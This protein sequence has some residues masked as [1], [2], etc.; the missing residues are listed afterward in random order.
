[1]PKGRRG[2]LLIVEDDPVVGAVLTLLVSTVHEVDSFSNGQ[3]AL[4]RFVPGQYDAALIDLGMPEMP[5]DHLA[6][7]LRRLDPLV[8]TVMVTGWD[9]DTA[10]PRL[11]AF[12]FRVQKPIASVEMQ[13]VV[14]QAVVLHDER[15]DSQGNGRRS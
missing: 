13:R 5:G 12:D 15:V 11:Q 9:L 8:S 3:E 2:R 7:E 4:E 1:V 14:A 10:D 6:Q